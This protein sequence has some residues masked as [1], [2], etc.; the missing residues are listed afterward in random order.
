MLRV[1]ET[2]R[3]GV[4]TYKGTPLG[5]KYKDREELEVC[6]DNPQRLREIIS[7][8]GYVPGFRYEKYRTEYRRPH[9]SGAAML[10]ETPVGV[11]LEL[12]GAPR[13]IDRAARSLGFSQSDY[14]TA[15]YYDL[16][17]DYCRK[18][19][20]KVSNM[21]YPTNSPRITVTA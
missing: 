4:L 18:H 21:T 19:R 13:W 5:G 14:S 16:Y 7:R 6:V 20:L 1:R 17:V 3:H 2:G 8:L 11:Y 12:E 9:E 10:D 15:S